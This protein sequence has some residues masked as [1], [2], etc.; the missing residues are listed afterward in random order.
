MLKEDYDYTA[1]HLHEHGA[2]C[3]S[4]RILCLFEHYTNSGGAVD[5]RDDVRE[6]FVIQ[7]LHHKWPGAFRQHGTR[8]PNEVIF[9]WDQRD[10]SLGGRKTHERVPPPEGIPPV[11][12]VRKPK[13]GQTTLTG[14]LKKKSK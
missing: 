10:K 1:Q 6:Q 8:G 12:I 9:A 3:R 13:G 4:N 2:V 11:D 14:F 5:V 7:L